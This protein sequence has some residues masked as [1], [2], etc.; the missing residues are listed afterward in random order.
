MSP[1]TVKLFEPLQIIDA[2]ENLD[3]NFGAF[4]KVPEPVDEIV[5]PAP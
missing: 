4:P 1:I 3:L 2:A 5:T